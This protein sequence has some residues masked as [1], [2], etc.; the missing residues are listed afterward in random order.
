MDNKVR[1]L[2][3]TIGNLKKL[4]YLNLDGNPIESLPT[5]IGEL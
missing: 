3:R 4:V 5:E 2:P 1:T